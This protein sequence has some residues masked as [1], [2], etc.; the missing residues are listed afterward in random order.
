M[1]KVLVKRM[2]TAP[3]RPLYKKL[4]HQYCKKNPMKLTDQVFY[5]KFQR[6]IDWDNPQ[7]LNEKINWLKFHVNPREWA[8]LADKYTV[9]EYVASRGLSDILVPL[10]GHWSSVEDFFKA[11]NL[12]P[13]EFVLKSNNGSQHVVFVTKDQG[14]KKGINLD[15]L[16]GILQ[17]W[18]DEKEY[19]IEY[20]E[21]HYQFIDNCIIAEGL[22]KDDSVKTFSRSLVD[23]KIWCF[24]GEPYGCLLA[25]DREIGTTHHYLDYYDLEWNE[26]TD[27]MSDRSPRQPVPKP[28]NWERMIDIARVLSEGHPQM[29]VDLYNVGGKIYFG[30]L[31]MTSANALMDYFSTE[32]LLN[33]GK[34]IQLDLT[35]PWNEFAERRRKK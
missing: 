6:H 35:M 21:L 8:K 1:N 19:N 25:Y 12:L 16:S 18:L 26:R 33:M 32:L 28:D 22:L 13:D 9:R 2:V 27:L 11:W 4:K 5:T 3:I 15:E 34:K 17:S 30:E 10:Y 24:N 20:A 7:D 14:G 29:R 23:Y 31:T